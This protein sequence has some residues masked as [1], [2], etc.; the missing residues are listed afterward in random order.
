M[1]SSQYGDVPISDTGAKS[2]ARSYERPLNSVSAVVCDD[3]I[4]S[5]DGKT[6]RGSQDV[7][8]GRYA[9]HMVS[10]W[11]AANE[12]TLG[13]IRTDSKSNEIH[14]VKQLLELLDLE[15]SIIT[16]D[17]MGCQREIAA[18]IVA[19]KADYILAVKQNQQTLYDEIAGAFAYPVGKGKPRTPDS[20]PRTG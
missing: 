3:T 8:N 4:I 19:K 15:G 1:I 7:T 20:R 9:I 16:L 17:A 10:A 5:I 18:A 2:L 14:A 12:M 11:C 6:V 13:Q